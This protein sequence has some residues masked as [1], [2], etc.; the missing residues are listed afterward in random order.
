V[1]LRKSLGK[2]QGLPLS[3]AQV[4]AGVEVEDAHLKWPYVTLF[5]GDRCK[6]G[7]LMHFRV[8]A[9]GKRRPLA[10]AQGYLL[11]RCAYLKAY[12]RPSAR[13]VPDGRRALKRLDPE[14]RKGGDCGD[15]STRNAA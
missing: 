12:H 1:A 8:A 7:L 15:T 14:R 3:A 11:R 13:R 5:K 10:D 9:I 4:E 2:S 6:L